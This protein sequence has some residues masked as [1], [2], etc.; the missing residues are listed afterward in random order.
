MSR[1]PIERGLEIEQAQLRG[2]ARTIAEIEWLLLI[3]VVLYLFIAAWPPGVNAAILLGLAV[4][5]LVPIRYVY[6][7]R[8]LFWRV[9]TLALGLL[10]G[11][12]MLLMLWQ[13]PAV[14][15]ALFAG[16]L[17]FP[18]YYLALSL[19]LHARRRTRTA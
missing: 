1:D 11:V 13:Y 2:F 12:A 3:L 17:L 7:S 6:P 10:W 15:P 16:S 19:I 9:P 8:T 4:L 14:S 5:V 18:A